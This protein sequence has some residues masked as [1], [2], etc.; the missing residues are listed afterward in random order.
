MSGNGQ[1]SYGTLDCL[2][3]V[4]AFHKTFRHPIVSEPAIPEPSR[5]DLRIRL[6]REELNELQEAV[7]QGDITEAADAL[8]DLQYVL[9]GAILEFGLADRF[10]ALFNEVQR[11]NMSKA[12]SS[13]EEAEE[14]I[15]WY[16]EQKGEEAYMEEHEGMYLV[17]RKHDKKTLKSIRYSPAHLEPLV[18][19]KS[20]C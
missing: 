7:D 20:E 19:G 6:I 13:R 17:Y 11:S 3:Q 14:T 12:C 15:H 5:A 10:P 8:C 4:A 1:K 9:S 18:Q 16:D 2:N